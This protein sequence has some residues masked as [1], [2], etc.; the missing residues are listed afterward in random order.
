MVYL[1]ILVEGIFMNIMWKL[2]SMNGLY[3]LVINF[4]V[5][6]DFILIIIWLGF[7]KLLIVL[8][9]FRNLGLEVILNFILVF[10]LFNFF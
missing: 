4:F 2:F 3:S 6:F 7:I 1:V 8:F 9:F 5:C 10:C